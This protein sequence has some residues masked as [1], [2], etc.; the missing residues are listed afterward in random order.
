[1]K[2]QSKVNKAKVSV[3]MGS[4][5]DMETVEETVKLLKAFSVDYE[6]KVLSAHRTPKDL[7]AYVEGFCQR[8]V[9]VVIAAAGMSAALAGTIAA[10]TS[11]PV[12]GIPMESGTLKGLDSLLSTVQMPKGIPV[13]CMAIGKSG[14]QNAAIFAIQILAL[15]DE[16]LAKKM[17]KFKKDMAEAILNTKT[18]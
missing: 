7:I 4:K 8:G 9:A 11:L 5:S 14:A 15:K 12:I 3:L 18:S 2:G 6:L 10:H 13:A 1:M 17:I 16:T